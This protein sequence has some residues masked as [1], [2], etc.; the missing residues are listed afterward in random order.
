MSKVLQ[1][2]SLRNSAWKV[3]SVWSKGSNLHLLIYSA[4]GHEETLSVLE[5]TADLNFQYHPKG[6][7]VPNSCPREGNALFL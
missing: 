4:G 2:G 1:S 6:T 5:K 3:A 7:C